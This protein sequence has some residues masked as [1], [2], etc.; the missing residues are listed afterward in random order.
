MSTLADVLEKVES[1]DHKKVRLYFITRDIKPGIPKSR[2]MLDKYKFS[3]FSIEI[4]ENL[5][6]HLHETLLEQI[7]AK[8]DGD[9]YELVEYEVIDDDTDKV[10]TYTL[11]G[12]KILPFSAAIKDQL[13]EGVD[14]KPVTK[15][16]EVRDQIW[17]Y[18]ICVL[19]DDKVPTFSL[20][21]FFPSKIGVD[22]PQGGFLDKMAS[23]FT[24]YF[25][26]T[27]TKLQLFRGQTISFD[28][29]VD[30]LYLDDRFYIFSKR[31]FERIVGLE[32]EFKQV[33]QAL[34]DELDALGMIVGLEVISAEIER[35]PT[36]L[37]RL[38]KLAQRDDYK[39]LSKER[40]FKMQEI[41]EQHGLQL[42]VENN[43]LKIEDNKDIDIILKML[44]DYY[45][46]SVQTGLNYGSHAKKQLQ[47]VSTP[48]R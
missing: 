23:S 43:Q 34:V 32:E 13:S 40:I 47:P 16:H 6:K 9:K 41:A 10:L 8:A 12:N 39:S 36:L 42:K 22:E 11:D 17:A 44:D 25:D 33:A 29:R 24:T 46:E 26:T 5:Q 2:K 48:G 30:C 27:T 38:A 21:K 45:L 7:S 35:N 3:S 28:K 31:N 15:L 18:C 19:H 1:E 20:R 37:K 14:I 4:D